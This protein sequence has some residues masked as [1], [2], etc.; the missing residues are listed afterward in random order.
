M[1]RYLKVLV[2]LRF[3]SIFS[4]YY[5]VT[6]SYQDTREFT[7]IQPGFL[8]GLD[9]EL[10][11]DLWNQSG[12]AWQSLLSEFSDHS[13]PEKIVVAV[14]H[15]AVHIALLA[16]SL[17]VTKKEWMG[18]FH[19]DAGSISVVDFPDGVNDRGVISC[20]NFSAHL[21]RWAIPITRSTWD[22][23]EF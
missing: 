11:S 6:C 9:D 1:G 10:A 14:G 19:V 7:V 21:G 17:N 16:H 2:M 18:C 8:H 13:E 4:A 15:P 5:L 3:Q 22:D 20:I 12:R 23:E